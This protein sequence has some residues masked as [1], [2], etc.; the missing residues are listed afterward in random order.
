MN[1]EFLDEAD[2]VILAHFMGDTEIDG[3]WS[4]W[5]AK[6]LQLDGNFTLKE[7]QIFVNAMNAMNAMRERRIKE[8]LA[9]LPIKVGRT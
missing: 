5:S 3:F 2:R 8:A 4:F 1:T 7:L 9:P 6:E